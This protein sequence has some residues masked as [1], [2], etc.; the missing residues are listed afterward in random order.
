MQLKNKHDNFDDYFAHLKKITFAGRFFK[1]FIA[2]PILYFQA[3]RFGHR[4]IEIGSGTGSGILG[5]FPNSV[6]G[7]EINPAAVAYCQ[8]LGM[9]VQL[10]KEDGIFPV[11]DATIDVCVLD[12]V[13]E[14]IMDARNTLDECHRVTIKNGGLVIAV[15]GI[16]GYASDDDHK[17]FYGVDDLRHL[18]ERWKLVSLFSTPFF[19]KGE[20]VSKVL[21]QY[22]LVA[23]YKKI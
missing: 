3:R 4:I 10:V 23:T 9:Q 21:K 22:C 13:L 19:I 2:S 12:N 17:K 1:R 11:P 16:R 15:P 18:D 8:A 7:L 6:H 5:A 20:Y 14:H